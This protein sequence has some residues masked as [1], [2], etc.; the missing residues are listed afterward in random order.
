MTR[1]KRFLAGAFLAVTIAATTASPALADMH[2]TVVPSKNDMHATVVSS[3][4]DMH[5]TVAPSK[6]TATSVG[7]DD[8]HAT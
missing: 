7:T 6:T 1:S 8:M 2:A 3:T 4:D 5:A